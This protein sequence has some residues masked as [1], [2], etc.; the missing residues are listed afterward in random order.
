[1]AVSNFELDRLADMMIRSS[2]KDSDK[3]FILSEDQILNRMSH[4]VYVSSGFP[5]PVYYRGIFGRAHN[6][7]D[8]RPTNRRRY[9]IDSWGQDMWESF[10]ND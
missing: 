9:S 7:S 10:H 6:Y 2:M 1:M 8:L 5:D 4:E 3:G